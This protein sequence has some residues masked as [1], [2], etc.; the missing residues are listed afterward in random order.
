MGMD[1]NDAYNL[2]VPAIDADHRILL[3][4][5]GEFVE[6]A[7]NGAEVMVLA[8]ILD[9][10]IL[11]TRIHFEAEEKLLD[12]H[13]YPQLAAHKSD[14]DRLITQAETLKAGFGR[15]SPG[16]RDGIERLTRETADF[17]QAWLVDHIIQ[18][19]KPY[20]PFLMNLA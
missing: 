2:G 10:L 6:A 14:H 17:L 7:G 11:R 18:G 20:R 3:D 12:R 5:C 19:D 15:V 13:H 8:V 9:K 16:D 1:W 4:L